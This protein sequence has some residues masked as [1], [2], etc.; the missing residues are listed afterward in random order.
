MIGFITGVNVT[1]SANGDQGANGTFYVNIN[2]SLPFNTV[3]A[4][5]TGNAFEFD[6]VA[7]ATTTATSVPE[8][9]SFAMLGTGLLLLGLAMQLRRKVSRT[10]P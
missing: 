1:N 8:P 2:S 5:S 10:I 3:V 4:S 7:Y 9:A 6:N